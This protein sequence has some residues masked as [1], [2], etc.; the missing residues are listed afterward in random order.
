MCDPRSTNR[1]LI[2]RAEHARK[3]V[4]RADFLL[5]SVSKLLRTA[6][7]FGNAGK[8]RQQC[9]HPRLDR[10]GRN[11]AIKAERACDTPDHVRR[12]KFHNERYEVH[13]HL[14]FSASHPS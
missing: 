11:V 9:R 10:G 14:P 2:R 4:E 3:F 6:G 1:R 12:Q 13:G 8:R 7:F 5:C